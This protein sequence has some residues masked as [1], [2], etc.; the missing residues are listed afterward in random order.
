MPLP[1]KLDLSVPEALKGR[2][3]TCPGGELFREL[4]KKRGRREDQPFFDPVGAYEPEVAL[5]TIAETQVADA[6]SE[7]FFVFAHDMAILGVV[8]A[9][10]KPANEWYKKGWRE[11]SLWAFL[12]DLMPA[13]PPT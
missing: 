6:K 9:F 12:L 13:L 1:D 5:K 2:F 4:N 3:A 10:P 11:K 8:D 7:V